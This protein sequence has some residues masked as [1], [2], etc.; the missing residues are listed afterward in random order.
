MESGFP[1]SGFRPASVH[2]FFKEQMALHFFWKTG[3]MKEAFLRT[4]KLIKAVFL[5]YAV[6]FTVTAT[7]VLLWGFS[8]AIRPINEVK[9]L[10]NENPATTIVMRETKAGLKAAKKSSLLLHAFVPLD[11]IAEHL[12]HAVLAAEDD[13]FYQHPG[14]DLQA[15]ARAIDYNA[16][17]NYNAR[18]A[19]TITQQM[20]KNLFT[21]AEKSF[22]RKY[23]ELLYAFLM[24][25]Y[26][27]KDRILELYCNYAQWGDSIFG[28]E[29]AARHYFG[30]PASQLTLLES[31][32]L[33]AVLA[34]PERL[35]PHYTK[36]SFLQ[37][38]LFVIAENMYR[39]GHI[40]AQGYMALTGR[41]Y[42]TVHAVEEA[43]DT[44][45][46]SNERAP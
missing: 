11:S 19:S 32:R 39:R 2:I 13:G 17:K 7:I 43:R 12:V 31:A 14:I 15:I 5:A 45:S 42:N 25:R 30:K 27:G 46:D 37:K 34:M 21:G 4:W 10:R 3:R 1:A 38:R 22:R 6:F 24:E 29:A 16:E 35:N 33:A 9:T 41:D 28:G 23:R 26:L 36:S 8:M 20:A 40:G 18:G 44:T